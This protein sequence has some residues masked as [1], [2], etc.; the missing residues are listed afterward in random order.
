MVACADDSLSRSGR[1]NDDVIVRVEEDQEDPSTVPTTHENLLDDTA[2]TWPTAEGYT[3]LGDMFSMGSVLVAMPPGDDDDEDN[4]TTYYSSGPNA[5]VADPSELFG[6]AA[7]LLNDQDN[8]NENDNDTYEHDTTTDGTGDPNSASMGAAAFRDAASSAL[9]ALENDYMMT[10]QGHVRPSLMDSQPSAMGGPA[11]PL[12]GPS[13]LDPPI[14]KDDNN[15]ATEFF[16]DFDSANITGV[17]TQTETKPMPDIDSAAVQKAVAGIINNTSDS[18][19]A[20]LRRW[21]DEQDRTLKERK[22]KKEHDLIPSAPFK[23]FR[24]ATP[25]AIQATATLTRAATIAESLHRLSG[26]LLSQDCLNIHIVGAD[27]VECQSEDR[28]RHHFS[29]LA[30]WIGNNTYSPRTVKLS[31][32]GPNVPSSMASLPNPTNLLTTPPEK[33]Q[34]VHRLRTAEAKCYEASYHD[35]LAEQRQTQQ[36]LPDLVVCFNAGIWGYDEWKP[37]IRCLLDLKDSAIPFLVTSYTLLEAEDDF[38]VIQEV[39]NSVKE[40][41]TKDPNDMPHKKKMQYI[42]GPEDNRFG[43]KQKR[44]TATALEGREYRENAAWQ[45]WRL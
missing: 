4:G 26:L 19:G 41:K 37:T 16:A 3:P 11:M 13:S 28:I 34:A 1:R 6:T 21:Q 24:K 14:T 10:V 35:W 15:N 18:L 20:K 2:H 31:L 44:E 45:A 9:M 22:E 8:D 12:F 30:R 40:T 42:W 17:A 25:K 23:A 39:V 32:V 33:D 43:S 29:P 36:G 5:F 38:D 27:H 7:A